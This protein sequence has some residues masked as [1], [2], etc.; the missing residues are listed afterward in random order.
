MDGRHWQWTAAAADDG[1]VQMCDVESAGGKTLSSVSLLGALLGKMRATSYVSEGAPLSIA[2]PSIVATDG[3]EARAVSTL[4]DAAAIG[5]WKLVAAPT[6]A[7]ALGVALA[8]KWPFAKADEGTRPRLVLILDMGASSTVVAVIKLTPPLGG[9]VGT[10]E[11]SHEVVATGSDP[12]L[13]AALFDAKLLDHFAAQIAAKYGEGVSMAS[14]RG[15]RLSVAT[16]RLRKLLSTMKEASATAENLIDGIDV[17][18]TATRDEFNELC[19]EPLARLRTL[20]DTTLASVANAMDVGADDTAA[21]AALNAV[22]MVGGGC[23]MP[24]V[25]Q[26]LSEALAAS[27]AAGEAIAAEKPGAKLDDSS[28]ALGAAIIGRRAIEAAAAAGESAVPPPA[29]LLAADA[30]QA[31]IEQEQAFAA[32]DAAAAAKGAVR[33]ELES[34]VLDSRNLSSRKHGE[35]VDTAKLNP[36][37]DATEEWIYSDEAEAATVDVLQAKLQEVKEQVAAATSAYAAAV[38]ADKLA[39]EKALEVAAAAAA[40]ERAANGEDEDHDQRKLKFPDRL[41]MVQKNKEEGTELFKGAVDVTQFRG[42]CAR[43]NKA[44]GHCAKFVDLS[45]DQKEEV[46]ALKLSLNLNIAMCWLKITDAENHLDQA[47]RACDEAISIDGDCVKALFRRATAREQKGQYDDA[48]ADLKKCAELAPDDK[49]VPKLMTRVEAQIARQK[50]KEK[51]MYG[52]MFG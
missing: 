23:R 50:A 3:A 20:L 19:S 18:L 29:G 21:S 52:K 32:Q 16:E 1:S 33:N 40:A 42:A 12:F 11:A 46:N 7:E 30:L 35:K 14:R 45:P 43:Y 24:C 36:L 49:A 17:P 10:A 28:I 22:E 13:G 6:A 25:Q 41:R 31:L 39:E 26:V 38:E 47:I 51:K 5:G 4:A 15:L 27:A 34:Y 2:L 37:L 9:E 48:K 44:L 8:R